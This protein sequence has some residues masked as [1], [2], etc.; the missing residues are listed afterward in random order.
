MRVS[1]HFVLITVILGSFP[2]SAQEKS[3]LT[4]TAKVVTAA[5]AV[6]R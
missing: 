5:Q 6:N 3:T 4:P 1:I 2:A